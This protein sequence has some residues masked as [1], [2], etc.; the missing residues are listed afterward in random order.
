[1][2]PLDS[3]PAQEEY[4][5]YALR[6]L[7]RG[8]FGLGWKHLQNGLMQGLLPSSGSGPAMGL[9]R[10]IELR[11]ASLLAECH[12][13]YG[14]YDEAASALAPWEPQ[15]YEWL[16][17]LAGN[18]AASEKTRRSQDEAG[19]K[20][21]RQIGYVLHQM[22]VSDYRRQEFGRA[23]VRIEYCLRFATELLEPVPHSVVKRLLFAQGKLALRE[24]Q[25]EVA[26]K[27]FRSALLRAEADYS[28]RRD[29]LS[30]DINLA[31]KHGDRV[32]FVHRL[33][34]ELLEEER[35]FGSW[36]GQVF[37]LG[38]GQAYLALGNVDEARTM[39]IGGLL[40]LNPS[41]D[42]HAAYARM[43]LAKAERLS[44]GR[45][46]KQQLEEAGRRLAQCRKVFAVHFGHRLSHLDLRAWHEAALNA[47]ALGRFAE[48]KSSLRQL[49]D[50]VEKPGELIAGRARWLVS[51]RL[52]LS[53]V[54]LQAKDFAEAM[55]QAH[56]ARRIAQLECQHALLEKAELAEHE[57]VACAALREVDGAPALGVVAENLDRLLHRL[58]D[59]PLRALPALRL[60]QVRLKLGDP[61]GARAAMAEFR[62][63]EQLVSVTAIRELAGE[64]SE[65]LTQ[66]RAL[67]LPVDETGEMELDANLRAFVEHLL[68]ALPSK[69]GSEPWKE[70][71]VPKSTF[72]EIKRAIAQGKVTLRASAPRRG[73]SSARR[74]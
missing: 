59:S 51:G 49:L 2:K 36:T 7:R 40:L 19:W 30:R 22:A 58:S 18:G 27:A 73:K 14:R 55:T 17:V 72:Y 31:G 50:R 46:A 32:E 48:A 67:R 61:V 3:L 71:R 10:G 60:T 52:G 53:E 15:I 42:L 57:A 34:S 33:E 35:V 37:A 26:V 41:D 29:R 62:S 12:D 54:A 44:A 47:A 20:Y 68:A 23:R 6:M 25:P 63:C 38:L 4:L 70:L 11:V 56:E 13:Y 24:R 69:R 65:A 45:K 74:S 16:A 66:F 9:P 39:I 5:A 8:D 28:L 43:V 1:M 21:R 64:V